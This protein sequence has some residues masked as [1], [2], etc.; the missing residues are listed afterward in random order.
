MK[1]L[2]Y[3]GIGLLVVAA[4]GLIT[5]VIGMIM[6]ALIVLFAKGWVFFLSIL[7]IFAIY[8]LGQGI[9]LEERNRKESR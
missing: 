8:K 5:F 6:I 1:H 7:A 9:Y 3:F 4:L 2:K